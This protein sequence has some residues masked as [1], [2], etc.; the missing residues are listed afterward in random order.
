MKCCWNNIEIQI[1]LLAL[2]NV[3]VNHSLLLE[4]TLT[5]AFPIDQRSAGPVQPGAFSTIHDFGLT[6]LAAGGGGTLGP[7][8]TRVRLFTILL[9]QHWLYQEVLFALFPTGSP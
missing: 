3:Q 4:Y 2:S 6:A 9:P 5:T 7:A 8:D 1:S